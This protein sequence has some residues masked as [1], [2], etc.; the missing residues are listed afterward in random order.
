MR[1][2]YG[3]SLGQMT[4]LMGALVCATLQFAAAQ[5]S[6]GAVS[7]FVD[8]TTALQQLSLASIESGHAS[9]AGTPVAVQ[10]AYLKNVVGNSTGLGKQSV[11]GPSFNSLQRIYPHQICTAASVV[12]LVGDF[13][14]LH[15]LAK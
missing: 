9:A 10:E 7:A 5:P 6:T 12:S 8:P 2:S 15:S 4:V 3:P 1:S 13:C 11:R 14:N